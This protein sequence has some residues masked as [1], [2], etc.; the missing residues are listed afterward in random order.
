MS[1]NF[2]SPEIRRQMQDQPEVF[3]YLGSVILG[4]IVVLLTTLMFI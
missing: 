4:G 1:S 2:I 3:V